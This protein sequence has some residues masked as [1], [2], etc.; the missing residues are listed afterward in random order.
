[1]APLCRKHSKSLKN[2]MQGFSQPPYVVG[3]S[4]SHYREGNGYIERL[5]VMSK[6]TEVNYWTGIGTQPCLSQKPRMSL[7]YPPSSLRNEILHS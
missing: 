6:E 7:A 4:G 1:M 2:I 5:G 3:T